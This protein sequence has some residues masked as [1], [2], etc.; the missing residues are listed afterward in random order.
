MK[1]SRA[2]RLVQIDI[3]I[4][5]TH[6]ALFLEGLESRNNF[7]QTN[8]GMEA[9]LN[10]GENHDRSIGSSP[11]AGHSIR[12]SYTGKA[13][14]VPE[15]S[16]GFKSRRNGNGIVESKT[17]SIMS[18]VTTFILEELV[19]QGIA[20]C[21]ERTALGVIELRAIWTSRPASDRGSCRACKYGTELELL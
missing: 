18:F 9:G 6:A 14:Y 7:V 11:S 8:V 5:D 17:K 10:V 4:S 2:R 12:I 19:L 1:V 21:D 13:P 3:Q 20:H 15:L 16:L